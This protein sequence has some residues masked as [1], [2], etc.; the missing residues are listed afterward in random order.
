MSEKQEEVTEDQAR[1][2][3]S[4]L[5]RAEGE[6]AASASVPIFWIIRDR[7]R[8]HRAR[9]GTG[10]FLNTGA[11][12]FGVT[13]NH[14]LEGWRNDCDTKQVTALQF[15]DLPF[16]PGGRNAIIGAHADI[17]I[18]TFHVSPEEVR[19]VGKTPLTGYQSE[20]PPAPPHQ[21]RGIYYAGFP[22]TEKIWLSSREISFG[23]AY[24]GGVASSVSERDVSSLIERDYIMPVRDGPPIPPENYNF[25]G[26]S[27]GPMLSVINHKGLRT[28]ALAGVIHQGPNTEPDPNK[29]I[30]G[31][32]IIKA[33]RAHFIL[34][35]GSLDV[36][37]WDS[38]R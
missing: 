5:G 1:T 29:A 34:P 35:D 30:R 13:A 15:G 20:W 24:A 12:L 19:K 14:V 18:A 9:N 22:G 6:F 38:L 3:M 36:A 25:Q 11:R 27:G 4:V 31:L 16:D 26:I 33:R 21:G 23:V 17:D 8:Q 2:I 32:E 7:E 10:F 28:W 37:R